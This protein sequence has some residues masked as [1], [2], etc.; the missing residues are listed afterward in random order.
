MQKHHW[1][2]GSTLK[3]YV[4]QQ[5]GLSNENTSKHVIVEGNNFTVLTKKQRTE[6]M[7]INFPYGVVIPNCEIIFLAAS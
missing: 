1:R 2:H 7:A 6:M 5:Q 4:L 3:E